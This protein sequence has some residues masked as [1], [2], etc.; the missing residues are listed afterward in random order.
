VSLRQFNIYTGHGRESPMQL[1]K[2]GELATNT[3]LSNVDRYSN[4]TI[5]VSLVNSA[6]LESSVERTLFVGSK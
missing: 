1:V 5:G 6:G 2:S 4:L 3:V